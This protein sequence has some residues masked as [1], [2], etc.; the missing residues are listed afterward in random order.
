[1]SE[2]QK[3]Q[4]HSDFILE[5]FNF[6][7]H[8]AYIMEMCSKHLKSNYLPS[9]VEKDV[10]TELKYQYTREG[11]HPTYGTLKNV[12]RKD[13]EALEYIYQIQNTETSD[14]TNL[15]NT[16]EEFVKQAMY[17]EMYDASADEFNKGN[18][19]RAYKVFSEG[20][21]KFNSFSL[22]Q[23]L[24]E[25]VFAG[26]VPRH[27]KRVEEN[28]KGTVKMPTGIDELDYRTNGGPER[29][30]YWL[31][32]GDAKSGKSFLL[33]HM[34]VNYARRGY[35]VAHFQLEGTKKQS[36]NRY[37][38]YWTGSIYHEIKNGEISEEKFNAHKKIVSVLGKNDIHVH[39]PE[40]FNSLS[41]PQMRKMLRDLKKK[42]KI[43]VVIID[44]LDLAN[45]DGE[46]YKPSEERQRQQKTSRLF[47]EL[48]M[49]ENVLVISATQTSSINSEQL[50]DPDFVIR[51]QNLAEDR[52]KVR[53]VDA[54]ISINATAEE[55]KNN[56]CRLFIDAVR[57]HEG[58]DV[59]TIKRNLKRSRFYDR[60]ATLTE[61]LF[62]AA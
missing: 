46:V 56:L 20:I 39:A 48:A 15:L 57:E 7:L 11:K 60:K 9:K 55:R 30:E 2:Q 62:E 23:D 50:E 22:T 61:G 14:V 21:E 29:G 16:F 33:T 13:K 3:E 51:R 53:P 58:G 28:Q 49:E 35:G 26:F 8:D 59:I 27:I 5:L 37:D 47:K 43:D 6:A 42:Y 19:S 12:L 52:G 25:P 17:I 45:P 4:L 38:A 54:L 41:V 31:F 44:Y 32:V 40:K 34:G 10:F 18:H 36:L 24:F 1:M